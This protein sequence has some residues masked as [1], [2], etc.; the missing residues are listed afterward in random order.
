VVRWLVWRGGQYVL[1][2]PLAWYANRKYLSGSA[3]EVPSRLP[4]GD[5]ALAEQQRLLDR[6]EQRLQGIEGK[7]P[8]LATVCAVVA[9][10]IA[11]AISLAWPDAT[12][13]GRLL[14]GAAAFYAAMSLAAPIR[15]VGP[16]ERSTITIEFL[17][18]LVNRADGEEV[19]ARQSAQA[20]SDNDRAT[21]RL[22]NLLA[23]SRNDVRV[24]VLLFAIWGCLALFG[25]TS[26]P[27]RASLHGAAEPTAQLPLRT[28]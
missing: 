21:V 20:A 23:A 16:I 27:A 19:L 17:T 14:L 15:L 2:L 11:V 12:T 7:G 9:A 8:G 10:A 6:S 25:L 26:K 1:P 3:P 5:W 22:G 18:T 28:L 24:A 4:K 13:L